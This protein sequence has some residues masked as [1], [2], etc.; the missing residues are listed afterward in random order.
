[1]TLEIT[2][3]KGLAILH[4]GK[5]LSDAP[6]TYK[7]IGVLGHNIGNNYNSGTLTLYKNKQGILKYEIYRD[8]SIYPFYGTFEFVK[9]MRR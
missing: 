3:T 7:M 5:P 1:M 2:T 6:K 9:E 4:K 8:G